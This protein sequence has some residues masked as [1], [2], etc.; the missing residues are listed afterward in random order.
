VASQLI[1][2]DDTVVYG[3]S[4]YLGLEKREE[5]CINEHLSSIDY[6]TNRRPG[7]LYRMKDNGEQDWERLIE[8]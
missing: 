3:D 7:K 6:H 8:R 2:E 5:I 4:G 1:R